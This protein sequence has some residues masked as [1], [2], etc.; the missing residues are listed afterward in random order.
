[1][2]EVWVFPTSVQG[3]LE[4]LGVAAWFLLRGTFYAILAEMIFRPFARKVKKHFKSW[5]SKY[6]ERY[7]MLFHHFNQHPGHHAVCEDCK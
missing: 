7:Q 3:V 6:P 2:N 5:E 4:A 1:M